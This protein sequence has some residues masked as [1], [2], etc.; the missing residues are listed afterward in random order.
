M[1]HQDFCCADWVDEKCSLF[2]RCSGVGEQSGARKWWD[3]NMRDRL[4]SV[5]ICT[6]TVVCSVCR[7]HMDNVN[8]KKEKRNKKKRKIINNNQYRSLILFCSYLI[9]KLNTVWHKVIIL[10]QGSRIKFHSVLTA[11]EVTLLVIVYSTNLL[12]IAPQWAFLITKLIIVRL[13][14]MIEEHFVKIKLTTVVMIITLL[15]GKV[16]YFLSL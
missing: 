14:D 7:D 5:S 12:I 10:S 3:K 16:F 13:K 2:N 8:F 15:H 6:F 4:W 9:Q 11:C 1:C